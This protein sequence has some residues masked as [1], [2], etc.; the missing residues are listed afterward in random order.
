MGKPHPM[1]SRRPW[2]Q[3]FLAWQRLLR[4]HGQ[5]GV[6]PAFSLRAQQGAAADAGSQ[7]RS[8]FHLWPAPLSLGVDM[9]SAVKCS[10]NGVPHLPSRR[11]LRPWEET[12]PVTTTVD[13][14]DIRGLATTLLVS[15]GRLPRSRHERL[16]QALNANEGYAITGAASL[17]VA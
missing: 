3:S 16:F 5:R 10:R 9:T 17:P 1:I 7:T 13:H 14:A 8:S 11:P 15:V 6:V 4:V 12:E 2:F